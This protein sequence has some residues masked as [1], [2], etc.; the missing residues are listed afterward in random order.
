MKNKKN[1][2]VLDAS[3]EIANNFLLQLMED[4]ANLQGDAE[5]GRTLLAECMEIIE[6]LDRETRFLWIC[7]ATLGFGTL[8]IAYIQNF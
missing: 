5:I 7:L 4:N 3:D 1:V 8:A 6:T 2:N